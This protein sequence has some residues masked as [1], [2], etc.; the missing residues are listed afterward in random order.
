[1]F[2]VYETCF[3]RVIFSRARVQNLIICNKKLIWFSSTVRKAS[4][5]SK[6]EN[7]LSMLMWL[8][9]AIIETWANNYLKSINRITSMRMLETFNT[10]SEKLER[11][12]LCWSFSKRTVIFDVRA[13]ARIRLDTPV[14]K[15]FITFIT[16]IFKIISNGSIPSF[17][18]K[19]SS[20]YILN[21]RSV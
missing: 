17:L 11:I 15:I 5:S 1:M 20:F 4:R 12:W 7:F 16:K 14:L 8:L 10:R 3:S 18:S 2:R 19:S 21:C 13:G 6:L 9:Q